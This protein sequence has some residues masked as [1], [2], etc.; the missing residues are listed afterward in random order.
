VQPTVEADLRAM[1][2]SLERLVA[3]E[4]L[5][6]TAVQGLAEIGRSL[7][8]LER[9]WAQ[10]LPYLVAENASTA[11]LLADLT[12]SLPGDLAGEIA[13]LG[14]PPAPVSDP[15]AFDATK[16]QERNGVLRALLARAITALPADEGGAEARARVRQHLKSTLAL[17]P[18]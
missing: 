16:A 11:A 3:A 14:P 2:L 7:R 12:P 18:W 1:R 4:D 10:V 6:A 5:P 9:S 8:R 17:R 15:S 13:S